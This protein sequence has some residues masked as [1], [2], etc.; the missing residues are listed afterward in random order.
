M[1]WSVDWTRSA[2]ADPKKLSKRK[3]DRV[4][5]S[6]EPLAVSRQGNFERLRAFDSPEYRLRVGDWRVR[7]GYEDVGADELAISVVRV[8]H[9]REACRKS[10]LIRQDIP[11]PDGFDETD[12]L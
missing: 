2:R 7:L 6:V 9:R 1:A 3:S 5:R 11:G 8:L 4:E 10:A 12:D